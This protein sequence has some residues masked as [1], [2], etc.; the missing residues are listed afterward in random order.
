MIDF[1]SYYFNQRANFYLLGIELMFNNFGIDY[2]YDETKFSDYFIII[3][4][5]EGG[6]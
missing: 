4:H 3:K 6:K 1:F 5:I 2:L